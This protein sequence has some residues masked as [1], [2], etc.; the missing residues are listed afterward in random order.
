MLKTAGQSGVSVNN[1]IFTVPEY[2]GTTDACKHGLGGYI[3]TR[4]ICQWPLPRDLLWLFSINLL[5]F[6]A[7][8]V[9]IWPIL[10]N[11]PRN[12]RILCFTD[13]LSALG[14]LH[15]ST[16]NPVTQPLHD[17]IQQESYLATNAPCTCSTL[18]ENKTSL[19]IVCPETTNC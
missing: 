9:N 10:Y 14:W 4:S 1:I 2:V 12:K 13:N 3:K 8:L 19:Q 17:N 16:F 7:A 5:E 18:K 6:I 15:H 11:K